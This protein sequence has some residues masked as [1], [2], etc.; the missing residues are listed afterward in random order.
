MYNYLMKN[1]LIGTLIIIFVVILWNGFFA[2]QREFFPAFEIGQDNYN[3]LF[4]YCSTPISVDEYPKTV[5]ELEKSKYYDKDKELLYESLNK[6]TEAYLKEA[7]L[8][9]LLGDK[10]TRSN[11]NSFRTYFRKNTQYDAELYFDYNGK[12]MLIE[13]SK[14]LDNFVSYTCKY[15]KKGNLIEAIFSDDNY[16]I[17]FNSKKKIIYTLFFSHFGIDVSGNYAKYIID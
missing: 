6:T 9:D 1:F 2:I 11:K 5:N 17:H 13:N 16:A 4:E 7:E 8:F 12:L 15:S 3:R 14:T 10:V